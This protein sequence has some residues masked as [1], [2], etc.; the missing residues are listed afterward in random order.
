[1]ENEVMIALITAYKEL[2]PFNESL[3]AITGMG[4]IPA[5][6]TVL[7]CI[8][9]AITRFI[10]AFDN[11]NSDEDWDFLLDTLRN[12]TDVQAIKNTIMKKFTGDIFMTREIVDKKY[13]Y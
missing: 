6:D 11:N 12:D 8:E 3:R 13:D 7:D 2:Y 9:H 4:N 1:M 10:P 5:L